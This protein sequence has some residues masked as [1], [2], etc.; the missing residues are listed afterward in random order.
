MTA[1]GPPHA[2]RARRPQHTYWRPEEPAPGLCEFCG[3][4]GWVGV[5]PAEA[6]ALVERGPRWVCADCAEREP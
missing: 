4:A 1:L 3:A 5:E 2:H 6:G